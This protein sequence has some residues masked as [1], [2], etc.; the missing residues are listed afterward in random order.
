MS[1]RFRRTP[2]GP[3]LSQEARERQGKVVRAAQAALGEVDSVRGFLNN[4]HPRLRAR[5]I[6]LAIASDEGL[7]A[8]VSALAA[9]GQPT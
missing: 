9:E 1:P 5:P 6:D 3:V 4:P 2:T 8:V 7:A